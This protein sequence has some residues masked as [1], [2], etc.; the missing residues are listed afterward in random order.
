MTVDPPQP[1]DGGAGDWLEPGRLAVVFGCAGLAA[2]P[3]ERAFFAA[4]QPLG[5]ILFARNCEHPDQVAALV[6]DLRGCIGDP[7]AP[8][9][10]DQEGG[11]VQRLKPPHWRQA[12][13]ARL[14]GDLWRQN[15]TAGREAA[16]LNARLIGADLAAL[17]ITVNCAPVLDVAV[18]ETHQAVGDRA[19]GTDADLVTE[20]GRAVCQG[21]EAAGVTPVIKHLPGLGRASVDSHAELPTI[22]TDR[23]ELA[24]IDYAPFRALTDWPW[25]LVGHMIF[26]AVD[27][28]AAS[29]SPVIIADIIRG[30]IGFDGVLASDDINMRA[31]GGSVADRTRHLLAAGCDLVLHCNGDLAEME[32]V[33]AAAAPLTAA[34]RMRLLKAE[35]RRLTARQATLD[36]DAA[37]ARLTQLLGQSGDA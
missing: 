12:P 2:T 1:A 29:V 8:I 18:P 28:R 32:Q 4:S 25:G 34:A 16:D 6:D 13:P 23:G 35:R 21:L 37:L 17:G 19:Y 26:S 3:A 15:R 20:L 36:R 24:R 30:A 27:T 31:L 10:I 22:V 9:L 11:R 5:F 33:A 7:F 14:F